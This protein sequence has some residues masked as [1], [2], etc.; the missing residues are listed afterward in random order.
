MV[1]V[2]DAAADDAAPDTRGASAAALL[3]PRALLGLMGSLSSKGRDGMLSNSPTEVEDWNLLL[4]A[5]AESA[6]GAGAGAMSASL[7][8][9][10]L[11]V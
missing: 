7:R 6:L 2:E 11:L 9:S 5:S 1:D 10:L 3:S 4:A 8:S